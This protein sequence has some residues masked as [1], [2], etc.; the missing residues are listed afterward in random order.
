M[1]LLTHLGDFSDSLVQTFL[2][3]SS[4]S[5]TFTVMLLSPPTGFSFAGC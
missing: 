3:H 5:F 4:L 2:R 1:V